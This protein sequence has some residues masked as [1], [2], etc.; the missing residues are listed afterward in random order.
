MRVA[1]AQVFY[2]S[3][4]TLACLSGGMLAWATVAPPLDAGSD[5]A[6]LARGTNVT[7]LLQD[8]GGIHDVAAPRVGANSQG[9]GNGFVNRAYYCA[10]NTRWPGVDDRRTICSSNQGGPECASRSKRGR[11][12]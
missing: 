10:V 9:I 6:S 3:V 7:V 1:V 4:Y 12:Q 11:W 5:G 2:I 8:G